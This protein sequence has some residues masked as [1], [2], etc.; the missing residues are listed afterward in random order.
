MDEDLKTIEDALGFGEPLTREMKEELAQVCVR[1]LGGFLKDVRRIADAQ[2]K[3]AS[4]VGRTGTG[5]VL[6]TFP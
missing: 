2:E 4:C 1:L 3:L 5:S 6:K